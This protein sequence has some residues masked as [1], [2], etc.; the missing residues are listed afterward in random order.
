M[1]LENGKLVPQ[2]L[3]KNDSNAILSR[4]EMLSFI[5]EVG[6]VPLFKN[7]V[8][9]FSL[10]EHTIS[11]NWWGGNSLTDPWEWRNQISA[12]DTIIYGKF[13]NKKAGFISKD[14]FKYF[15]SYRRDGYDFDSRYEDGLA[16][17]KSKKIFDF[18]QKNGPTFSGTLKKETGFGKNGESGFETSITTLQMQTYVVIKE[19]SKKT[20]KHGTPY[21]MASSVYCTSEEYLGE[22]YIKDAYLTS[23]IYAKEKILNNIKEHF[24]NAEKSDYEKEVL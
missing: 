11:E 5:K 9:G 16:N 22:D 18:L 14:W 12:E 23:F 17:R 3:L 13:F 10:E 24:L 19:F 15:V 1:I 20:N 7:S 6:F 8:P 21:G 2:G 4:N